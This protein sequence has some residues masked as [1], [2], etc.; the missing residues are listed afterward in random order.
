MKK[1]VVVPTFNE[2]ANIER[3]VAEIF[4]AAPD[5]HVLVVDDRSPD[6]TSDIVRALC[7]RFPRLFLVERADDK[8]RGTAGITGFQFALRLGA[9][10]IAEMDADFSHPP[11]D[12]PALFR[13]IEGAD[14]ADIS[15]ASR[16]APGSRD[17]RPRTRRW[18]TAFANFYAR[19]F[20]ARPAQVSRVRDWTSGFRAYR[21]AVFEKV[22]PATWVSRGPSVLQEILFRALN[23]GLRAV[24]IP[25]EMK[26]RELGVS[27]FSRKVARQSF[28]SIPCYRILFGD[29][30]AARG[31]FHLDGY[32]IDQQNAQ[33]CVLW[34]HPPGRRR[35][36]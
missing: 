11:S 29:E 25:F 20:L 30:S 34:K 8:G 19:F 2:S 10:A 5:L 7:P 36:A 23:Q 28:L 22:P 9:D 12:L 32:S 6:G 18:I 33:C 17:L 27:T 4:A 15:I 24:E 14:G 3:L 21:K 1:F 13:A 35:A 26:D 31:V 16:L